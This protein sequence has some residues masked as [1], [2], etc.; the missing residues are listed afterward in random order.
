M[1]SKNQY[2]LQMIIINFINRLIENSKDSKI[3]QA[4]RAE[5]ANKP[6]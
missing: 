3:I 1:S 2:E 6:D 5:R 4:M